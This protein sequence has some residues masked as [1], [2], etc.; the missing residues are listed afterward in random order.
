MI[1][2]RAQCCSLIFINKSIGNDWPFLFDSLK[3]KSVG[4][5]DSLT[6]CLDCCFSFFAAYPRHH[7]SAFLASPQHHPSASLSSLQHHSSGSLASPQ[8]HSLPH[9]LVF[10][11]VCRSPLDSPLLLLLNSL[12]FHL[13]LH[14]RYILHF[15]LFLYSRSILH[16]HFVL[17]RS[18]HQLLKYC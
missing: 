4:C 14:S 8:H 3:L 17:Y 15:Y 18:V 6:L 9:D 12:Y 16:L 7:S 1:E 11:L 13:F 5:E 2:H 10:W